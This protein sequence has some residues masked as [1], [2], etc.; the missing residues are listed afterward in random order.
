ME[1]A[2]P[3]PGTIATPAEPQPVPL[4]IELFKAAMREHAGGVAVI[5]VGSGDDINGFTATSV[6]S[7]SARPPRVLVCVA[8]TAASW[9]VLQRYP[10]FAVNLLGARDQT[11]ADRFAGKDGLE[12]AERYGGNS[13]LAM[14]TATPTYANATA[15][16]DCDVEE[17]LPR[18]DHAIVIGR[19]R[20]VKVQSGTNPLVYWRGGY[21]HLDNIPPAPTRPSAP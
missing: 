18:Y 5:T 10:H 4:D 17:T 21:H 12:G 11:L 20:A 9:K 6:A 15:V 8:Q 3:A 2:V 19:V 7:L 13:W 14:A 16:L 1:H